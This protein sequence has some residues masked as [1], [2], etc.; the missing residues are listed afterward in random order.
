M[1]AYES[2]PSKTVGRCRKKTAQNSECEHN[3][4]VSNSRLTSCLVIRLDETF[5]HRC[6]T[7]YN[8]KLQ[9]VAHGFT[10]E[11]PSSGGGHDWNTGMLLNFAP[12][13]RRAL[14]SLRNSILDSE[15]EIN[16]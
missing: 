7:V 2:S 6:L 12:E 9:R 5:S 11:S 14:D 13:I 3:Y 8:V 10:L 16:T 15:R 4:K 1:K